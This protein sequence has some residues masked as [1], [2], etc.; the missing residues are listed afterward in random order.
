MPKTWSDLNAL[1]TTPHSECFIKSRKINDTSS[2][3]PGFGIWDEFVTTV[4]PFGVV[5]VFHCSFL[6]NTHEAQAPDDLYISCYWSVP[7]AGA[8][9]IE[10]HVRSPSSSQSG[11]IQ[12]HNNLKQKTADWADIWYL[13]SKHIWVF[14]NV[15]KWGMQGGYLNC[16]A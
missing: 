4:L 8:W 10:T 14:G 3:W 15:A 11:I 1:S 16:K 12:K 9:Y 13:L 5:C 6:A 7:Q 2:L